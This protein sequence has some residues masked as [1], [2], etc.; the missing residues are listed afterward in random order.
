MGHGSVQS[1]LY[2]SL[3]PTALT[4]FKQGAPTEVLVWT[5][6]SKGRAEEGEQYQ[7]FTVS[8][9]LRTPNVFRR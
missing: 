6:K 2:N 4:P 9:V 5:E 1:L 8:Q 3:P 7:F